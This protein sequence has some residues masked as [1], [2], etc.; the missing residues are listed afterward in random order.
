MNLD[1]SKQI[2]VPAIEDLQLM[3]RVE[4]RKPLKGKLEKCILLTLK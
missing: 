1:I 2:K 3:K 4:F